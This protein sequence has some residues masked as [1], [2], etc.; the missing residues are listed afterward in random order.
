MNMPV[1]R[2]NYYR[3]EDMTLEEMLEELYVVSFPDI[4]CSTSDGKWWA[5]AEMRI[6][7]QGADFKVRTEMR[8][9]T[10]SAALRQLVER[11][12]NA[13]KQLSE[14]QRGVA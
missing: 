2:S 14:S 10:P 4:H 6:K 11:V 3:V 5:M 8:H 1:V 9:E 12:R 7:V 13:M